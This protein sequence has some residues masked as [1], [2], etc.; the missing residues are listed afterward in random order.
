MSADKELNGY[1]RKRIEQSNQGMQMQL[2]DMKS[3]YECI[4]EIEGVIDAPL[5]KCERR[6]RELQLAIKNKRKE[7]G[8]LEEE[9]AKVRE[10]WDRIHD[11]GAQ[12]SYCV[13]TIESEI[14]AVRAKAIDLKSNLTDRSEDFKRAMNVAKK[15]GHSWSTHFTVT[16]MDSSQIDRDLKE[17]LEEEGEEEDREPPKKRASKARPEIDEDN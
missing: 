1:I 16:K 7:M 5:Y 9:L 15:Q 11:V 14:A 12:A 8:A 17:F 13:S 2:K 3:L 6:I 10:D 4:C